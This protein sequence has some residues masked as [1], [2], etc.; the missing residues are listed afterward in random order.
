MGA[1]S[2]AVDVAAEL[3]TEFGKTVTFYRE[4]PGTPLDADKPWRPNGLNPS[5]PVEYDVTAMTVPY[6]NKVIDGTVIK[7]G[8]L[9][10]LLAAKDLVY[11]PA[12]GDFAEIGGEKYRVLKVTILEPGVD[13]ILYDLQ[14]RA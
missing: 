8:D 4:V 11:T 14:L 12:V 2:W 1:L 9:N 3:L 13:R 6:A 5:T 10:C 7:R